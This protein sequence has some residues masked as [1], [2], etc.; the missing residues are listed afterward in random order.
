[1]S[2]LLEA[3]KGASESSKSKTKNGSGASSTAGTK[4]ES[5]AQKAALE[6]LEADLSDALKSGDGKKLRLAL[7][8]ARAYEDDDG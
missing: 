5:A 2:A 6:E 8:R 3:L 7:K 1:M 4:S